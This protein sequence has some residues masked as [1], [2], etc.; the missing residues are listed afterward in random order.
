MKK[1][2]ALVDCNNFFV[3]CERLF[4][5]GLNGRPVVVLS[6]NDGCII[7]RSNEAKSLGIPMGAPLFQYRHLIARHNVHVFSSNYALYGDLSCRVMDVLRQMEA[8][9]EVYSI[10]EAFLSLP[11]NTLWDR[12]GYAAT[13]RDR[14]QKHVGIPISVGIA[15]TKTL[16]KIANGVAKKDPRCRGVFDLVGN[17]QTDNILR[18]TAVGDVWGIGRRSAEK[19]NI[20]GIFTALDLKRSDETW[21]RKSMTV[22]GART[23]MELN[24][25]PCIA[26]QNA[27][28]CPQSIVTSRSFGQAVTDLGSLREALISYTSTATEKLRKQGVEAGTITV[29]ITTGPFAQHCYSNNQTIALPRPT[30]STPA[31]ISA[32]LQCLR[33]L[34]RPEYKYRKAGIMLS[35]IVKGYKQLDLFQP[36][37]KDDRSLMAGLD[38]ING[39]W[40]RHT[41]QY[42]MAKTTH[43]AWSAQQSQK[44]PAY[45][46]RWQELPVVRTAAS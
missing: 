8:N 20:R 38:R 7:A 30:A 37:A 31:L 36:A 1:V 42:G 40:G 35:G 28:V 21:I 12:G 16:A 45:T 44:S 25:I 19:L 13:L 27:P 22:V 9:V 4:R 6:N 2:F 15:N 18:Q 5:P 26:L 11:V 34:Y 41:I 29:F 39:K 24:D 32:A 43:T 14:V 46:T 10:D 17:S 33:S 3:S 23:V